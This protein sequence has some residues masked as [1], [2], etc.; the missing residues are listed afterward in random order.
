MRSY[1]CPKSVCFFFPISLSILPHVPV[2]SSKGLSP[3]MRLV[4]KNS[5]KKANAAGLLGERGRDAKGKVRKA[6]QSR[7]RLK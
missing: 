4:F 2:K 3:G 6:A 7:T 5:R 1:S